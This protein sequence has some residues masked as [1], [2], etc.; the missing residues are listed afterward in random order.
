[1]L[2]PEFLIFL[3]SFWYIKFK[4]LVVLLRYVFFICYIF[5]DL[6]KEMTKQPVVY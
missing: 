5:I 2:L 3:I 4:T 6:K 1:M